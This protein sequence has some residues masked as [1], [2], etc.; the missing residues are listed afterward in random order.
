MSRI[1]PILVVVALC[2]ALMAILASSFASPLGAAVMEVT[3]LRVETPPVLDGRLDDP[4]WR[5]ADVAEGFITESDQPFFLMVN[6]PDAHLPWLPQQGG[7]P[8]TLLTAADVQTLPFVGIDVPRL[9]ACTAD[10]YNCMRRLR[11]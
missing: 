3:A 8:E 2:L 5:N 9:R 7:L 6:Y 1:G 11:P 4:C 10:Y